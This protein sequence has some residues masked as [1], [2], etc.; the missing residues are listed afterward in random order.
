MV[1]EEKRLGNGFTVRSVIIILAVITFG[2][3]LNIIAWGALGFEA[4]VVNHIGATM[5]YQYG[6]ILILFIIWY[7]LSKYHVVSPPTIYELS[8][9]AVIIFIAGD[10][11]WYMNF[12]LP[13][14]FGAYPGFATEIIQYIPSYWAPIRNKE[15]LAGAFLGGSGVPGN[16]VPYLLYWSILTLVVFFTVLF[17]TLIFRKIMIDEEHLPFPQ[18]APVVEELKVLAGPKKDVPLVSRF[19]KW[20]M[21]GIVLG[22]LVALPATINFVYPIYQSFFV[23][24]QIYLTPL[25]QW[26]SGLNLNI[27][28]WWMFIPADLAILYLS[29]MDVLF[30]GVIWSILFIWVWPTIATL[31]LHTPSG[32]DV[33]WSGPLPV[34]YMWMYGLYF[35]LAIWV[36]YKHRASL[37]KS[38]KNA[39]T[40]VTR[41]NGEIPDKWLWGGFVLSWFAWLILFVAIGTPIIIALVYIILF[42]LL[43]VGM[44]R[45]VAENGMWPCM[46]I[47][48]SG[49]GSTG[50]L[51]N[52]L[53]QVALGLGIIK[54]NPEASQV[55]F[56][57]MVAPYLSF[58]DQ[59]WGYNGWGIMGGF[60]IAKN[61]GTSDISMLKGIIFSL[62]LGIPAAYFIAALVFYSM[63]LN[64]RLPNGFYYAPLRD[65]VKSMNYVTTSATPISEYQWLLII[66]G[67]IITLLALYMR[68]VYPWF[69]IN[70]TGFYLG[71]FP[72]FFLIVVPAWILK[73]ITLRTIGSKG[74][75]EVGVPIT[76]GFL[77]G[78]GIGA[79]IGPMILLIRYLLTL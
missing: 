2:T 29:P 34:G 39:L 73:T 76:V 74:Y 62:V 54:S 25:D 44:I 59:E 60:N 13:W 10:I 47:G 19:G 9:V 7:L 77:V 61:T 21:I 40:K 72:M 32:T 18:S 49:S 27:P 52:S 64:A 1:S 46:Y 8:V 36:L 45:M 3:F 16:L 79:F 33:L 11:P 37:L 68:T 15:L 28:G 41:T 78:L 23:W 71:L 63:G 6:I 26:A 56:G 4:G 5:H 42:L 17:S 12:S 65:G 14:L 24:G 50:F 20:F 43:N 48:Y 31:V 22:L 53:A 51:S 66:V 55:A 69:F 70:P 67:A 57:T 58:P 75:Q 38:L 35:G 30:T